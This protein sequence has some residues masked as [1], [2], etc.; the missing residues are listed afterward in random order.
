VFYATN[1]TRAP[2]RPGQ[3]FAHTQARNDGAEPLLKRSVYSNSAARTSGHIYNQFV[4]RTGRR[5]AVLEVLKARKVGAAVYYPRPM[6]LQEC[7]AD[8]ATARGTLPRAS[9]PAA[10]SSSRRCSP[11]CRGSSRKWL[12]RPLAKA[13]SGR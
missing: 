8:L 6:D 12:S 2:L 1:T 10:K 9:T 13:K 11:S 3:K 7:F 5:D 4:L